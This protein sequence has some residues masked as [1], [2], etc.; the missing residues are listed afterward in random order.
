[1]MRGVPKIIGNKHTYYP[2]VAKTFELWDYFTSSFRE[3]RWAVVSFLWVTISLASHT[4]SPSLALKE[5]GA[6][7]SIRLL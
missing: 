3:A 2:D 4:L 6:G 1:M 7:V 5:A